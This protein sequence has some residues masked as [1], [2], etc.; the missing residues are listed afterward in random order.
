MTQTTSLSWLEN[1]SYCGM[2]FQ[3]LSSLAP[4]LLL[5]VRNIIYALLF[6]SLITLTKTTANRANVNL[7]FTDT[8][9]KIESEMK[10]MRE[11]LGF[12]TASVEKS[13]A[14]GQLLGT[15][16]RKQMRPEMALSYIVIR[17]IMLSIRFEGGGYLGKALA[18]G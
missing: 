17:L 6:W 14:E 5:I 12:L 7:H 13:T 1:K 3:I 10:E 18:G 11:K 15:V 8:T 4:I 9:G 16:I 2:V